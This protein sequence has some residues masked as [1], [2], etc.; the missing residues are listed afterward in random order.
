MRFS[1]VV[2]VAVVGVLLFAVAS[3]SA[4]AGSSPAPAGTVDV[5]AIPNALSSLGATASAIA[6]EK[7]SAEKRKTPDEVAARLASRTAHANLERAA[8]AALV[9]SR[10][11]PMG[12]LAA[13]RAL[14]LEPG[15]TVKRFIGM[16]AAQVDLGNG[17][18]VVVATDVPMRTADAKG[19]MRVVDDG[20]SAAANGFQPK[21]PLVAVRF[22]RTLKDGMALPD[23][24]VS[25]SIAANDPTASGDLLDDT[26]GYINASPDTDVLLKAVP[27]GSE[28]SWLARSARSPEE[29]RFTPA[30]DAG[31]TL[32]L[33][34]LEGGAGIALVVDG[35]ETSVIAPPSAVDSDGV[36]IPVEMHVVGSDVVVTARHRDADV[37]YP[38]YIDPSIIDSRDWY[39]GSTNYAGIAYATN[40][41]NWFSVVASS[42]LWVGAYQGRAYNANDYGE[43]LEG[44]VHDAFINR[45]NLT[46]VTHVA[47]GTKFL[48]GLFDVR[49]ARWE[50]NAMYQL[51]GG[52][53]YAGAY[54]GSAALA[55]DQLTVCAAWSCEDW[56]GAAGNEL[57]TGLVVS[58]THTMTANAYSYVG[59]TQVYYSDSDTPQIQQLSSTMPG[60]WV[61]SQTIGATVRTTDPGVGPA[62]TLLGY[63]EA[64]ANDQPISPWTAATVSNTCFGAACSTSFDS[65]PSVNTADMPTG[66]WN[67]AIMGY[68]WINKHSDPLPYTV[69]V[70]HRAPGLDVAGSLPVAEGTTLNDS[71]YTLDLDTEDGAAGTPQSGVQH[72]KAT[73]G[74]PN[75]ESPVSLLDDNAACGDSCSKDPAAITV[76]PNDYTVGAHRVDVTA[77]D[78]IGGAAHTTT[79]QLAVTIP[80]GQLLAPASGQRFASLIPLQATTQRTGLTGVT[81]QYRRSASASWQDIPVAKVKRQDGSAVSS[82]PVALSSGDTGVLSWD[83]RTTSGVDDADGAIQVQAV[84]SGTANTGTSATAEVQ[85]DRN[86]LGATYA[87]A[88]VGPGVVTLASGNLALNE[89]DVSI[90]AIAGDLTVSRTYN[91]RQAADAN[92]GPLGPGWTLATPLVSVGVT[93]TRLDVL[94]GGSV[95]V[96]T[97]DGTQIPFTKTGAT[98]FSSPL[99]NKDLTLAGPTTGTYTLTDSDAN[100]VTFQPTVA[101]ATSFVPARIK[102]AADRTTTTWTYDSANGN[103]PTEATAPA[104]VG[105]TCTAGGSSVPAG[106]RKLLLSYATATTATG[107]AEAQ[108]GDYT[109]RLQ[110]VEFVAADPTTHQVTTTEVTRYLY[111]HQGRLRAAWDPR[112]SPQLKQRYSYNSDGVLDTYTPPGERAWSF[113]Y[114]APTGADANTGRLRSVSRDALPSGTATWTLAYDVPLNAPYAVSATDVA[115]W[116]QADVPQTAVA[117]FPPTQVPSSFPPSSYTDATVHYLDA[118]QLEVNTVRPGGAISVTEYDH[119]RNVTRTLTAANRAVAL[120]AGDPLSKARSIDTQRTYSIDGTQLRS[121]LGPEHTLRTG[122]GL[123]TGRS[124]TVYSYDATA[125]ATGG[126]YNLVTTK[127]TSALVGGVDE[128]A[129]TTT[130]GYGGQGGLG[131]Q[132]R[133]PT[134]VTTDPAG[135]NITTRTQYD[136]D[137]G[138]VTRVQQPSDGAGTTAG[139]TITDLYVAGSS[140]ASGCVNAPEMA[141]LPCRD[142]PASQ[143][144]GSSQPDI[145]T[146]TYAYNRLYEQTSAQDVSGSITRTT[147]TSYDSAGRQKTSAVTRSAGSNVP[148]STIDYDPATGRKTT[149]STSAGTITRAYDALGRLSSYTDAT[150]NQTTYSYDT[151]D[152]VVSVNDGKGTHTTAYD[153]NDNPASVTD[154][155]LTAAIT[156]TYDPDGRLRTQTFPNGLTAEY[157]YDATGAATGLSYTKTSNCSGACVWL[158][159]QQTYSASGQISDIA[160]PTG[161]LQQSYGYD[162]AGRLATVRDTQP[163]GCTTRVYDY[164][165]DSNRISLKSYAPLTGGS[166]DTGLASAPAEM[167]SNYDQ[168]DRLIGSGINYDALGNTNALPAASAGGAALSADYD[169]DNQISSLSQDGVTY[170]YTRDPERRVLARG[171]TGAKAL[172]Y[173]NDTD[174]P[175]WTGEN[176]G[177]SQYT[178]QIPGLDGNLVAI[179]DSQTGQ[180]TFQLADLSGSIAATA[181]ASPTVSGLASSYSADE[182]GVPR[183]S[184]P[185]FGWLGAK[186]RSA[187]YA[188][189]LVL[190]GQ[191]AYQPQTGRFLQVDPVPGGSANDYDYVN[192]DPLNSFDLS[193]TMPAPPDPPSRPARKA[194]PP[195]RKRTCSDA[196][197]ACKAGSTDRKQTGCCIR[198]YQECIQQRPCPDGSCNRQWRRPRKNS[199]GCYI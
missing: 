11:T 160:G 199:K 27:K 134:S 131:W 196:F 144:T 58:T 112:I 135:L 73:I 190:M 24:H 6:T 25:I 120:A 62:A 184:S 175:A 79:R 121:E 156:G 146:T 111:D 40:R 195:P 15:Q 106:C 174:N 75:G 172:H 168:A 102:Q 56:V 130:Y 89:T 54:L 173:G 22:P 148:T 39:G 61:D 95:V 74:G 115:Q 107:G 198:C 70:D 67:L 114:V 66:S 84:Y 188:T 180:A 38:V 185:R 123:T 99:G 133:K 157:S 181:G 122:S 2:V 52:T 177:E 92:P 9:R 23:D 176:V 139:T 192:Q 57:A 5:L 36:A 41:P 12:S 35:K 63:P 37:K 152:R 18:G 13:F 34:E 128:G 145:L 166:C 29:F 4:F 154:T 161:T 47:Q 30:G 85:L 3:V 110:K 68:D 189:G 7:A 183:S 119:H 143:P 101:S 132:L 96:T 105:V 138:Q 8:V 42:G 17:R 31:H 44:N 150:G 124:H 100:A 72:L 32:V 76:N 48:A 82:W 26:V 103:R 147:S 136:P 179:Y 169:A 87:T 83:A 191:R 65:T 197:W 129:R 55:N 167:A 64:D 43:W 137:T 88:N 140:G 142:W 59:G 163:A 46:A 94:S 90:A 60:G 178:R 117:I 162:N 20:L 158:N 81:F 21:N 113:G 33:R 125:P 28:I 151:S 77:I 78:G 182:F 19:E 86:F 194:S 171:T 1:R 153:L 16:S 71:S 187:E 53:K 91:S 49:G 116:G 193:G 14:T 80:P 97:A 141:G 126:P 93:Y 186:Q 155:Q 69:K 165:A 127:T 149:T 10:K 118:N 51:N 108:W 170:T 45:V 104:P 159:W 50:P 109:G 164:D 98:S